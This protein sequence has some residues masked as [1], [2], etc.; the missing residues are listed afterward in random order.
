[1]PD[2]APNTNPVHM[3]GLN[4]TSSSGTPCLHPE[5][6]SGSE[7][8]PAEGSWTPCILPETSSS[9][10]WKPKKTG[11]ADTVDDCC[12]VPPITAPRQSRA[13]NKTGEQ[14]NL[15]SK[16]V[17]QQGELQKHGKGWA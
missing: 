4:V 7:W 1:M 10:E 3:P 6:R 14:E 8:K 17:L 2:V 11:I 9:T 5:A 15:E 16:S 12:D 13:R